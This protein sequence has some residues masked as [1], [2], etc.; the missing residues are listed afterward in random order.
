MT[1]TFADTAQRQIQQ[2]IPFSAAL[3][4]KE[5]GRK[6]TSSRTALDCRDHKPYYVCKKKKFD[7][8]EKMLNKIM[9]KK[10]M[11][12]RNSVTFFFDQIS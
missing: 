2:S 6:C 3:E 5:H 9:E 10:E 12:E 7:I 8:I 4:R 11:E 1:Q